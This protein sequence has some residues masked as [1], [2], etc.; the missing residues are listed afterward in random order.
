MKEEN[1]ESVNVAKFEYNHGN[2]KD[3]EKQLKTPK[4]RQSKKAYIYCR[5]LR[6]FDDEAPRHKLGSPRMLEF[7]VVFDEL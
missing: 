5:F 3:Y 1:I 2:M 6:K 7:T 4:I